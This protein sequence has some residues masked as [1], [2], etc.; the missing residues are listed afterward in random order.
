MISV[1]LK[2]GVGVEVGPKLKLL[3]PETLQ[4]SNKLKYKYSQWR[5]E[6]WM[7]RVVSSLAL[8]NT[9]YAARHIVWP[10]KN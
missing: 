2:S 6:R 5:D 8:R 9:Q 7:M 10:N 4:A 1:A 3:Q